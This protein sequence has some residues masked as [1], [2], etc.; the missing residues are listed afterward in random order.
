MKTVLPI[1]SSINGLIDSLVIERAAKISKSNLSTENKDLLLFIFVQLIAIDDLSAEK[2]LANIKKST[3]EKIKEWH[4]N[5]TIYC[6]MTIKNGKRHGGFSMWNTKGDLLCEIPF[7]NGEMHGT[8]IFHKE[9][10]QE[11]IN[12]DH[13]YPILL[14]KNS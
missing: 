14:D 6:E 1:N 8:A 7:E 9:K 5:G 3:V 4:D 2:L 10:G 11:N 12:F 13:D